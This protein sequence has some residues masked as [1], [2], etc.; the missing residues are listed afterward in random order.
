MVPEYD[1]WLFDLDG[2]LVDVESDYR[3]EVMAGVEERLGLSFTDDKRYLLWHA[4][5]DIRT[6]ILPP[7]LTVRE[8]WEEFDEVD[9][10]IAR[11]E[12]TY[13]YD[14][15]DRITDID[16]PSGIVTHCPAPVADVVFD[17]LD[18][19][20]WFETIVCCSEEIGW[21]P[22]PEPVERAKSDL[23]V[24]YNGHQGVLAGDGACDIGAAWNAGLDGI[25]VERHDPDLLG[26]SVLGDYRLSSFAD[27]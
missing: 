24:A 18:I 6:D 12:S 23:E 2:T 26:H 13:L 21:K 11:A 9:D 19:R 8:F 17:H 4:T 7:D 15:A 16:A 10:P 5:D 27:L 14:D 1:Y 20:D 25:H 3:H 22:D